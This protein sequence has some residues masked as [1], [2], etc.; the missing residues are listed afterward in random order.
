MALQEILSARREY[1]S[2]HEHSYDPTV[3]IHFCEQTFCWHSFISSQDISLESKLYPNR[4]LQTAPCGVL[5]HRCSHFAFWQAIAV[6]KKNRHMNQLFVLNFINKKLS[7]LCLQWIFEKLVSLLVLASNW[8]L[9]NCISVNLS[10]LL[11]FL[12]Q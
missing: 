12:I 5:W 10:K 7:R 9:Q 11:V 1:S 4:Q 6:L 2:M 3:F 8:I